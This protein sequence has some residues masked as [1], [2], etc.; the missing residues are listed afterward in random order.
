[1][2]YLIKC[3]I[4]FM[5][6]GLAV[7]QSQAQI[8]LQLSM[9]RDDYILYEEVPLVVSIHNMSTRPVTLESGEDGKSWLFLQVYQGEA[10]MVREVKPL[11]LTD[12]VVVPPGESLSRQINLTPLFELRHRGLYKVQ[13]MVKSGTVSAASRTFEF[14]LINGQE[15]W[16]QRVGVRGDTQAE[17]SYRT[18][19][20]QLR[21]G[22]D[23]DYLYACVR[24]DDSGLVYGMLP[25]GVYI[26]LEPP[27]TMV[28]RTTDLHVMLRCG[29]RQMAYAKIDVYA[30][31]L[32]R[33]IYTDL[34]TAPY[35]ARS[36]NGSVAV[37]G[38]E[39]I[40][41]R[42]E[43]VMSAEELQPPPPPPQKK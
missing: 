1:M 31:I 19:A 3:A 38:G 24:D 32:D 43:R 23:H 42:Q 39:K 29:P 35:L 2:A 27:S 15:L 4:I 17:D 41:P 21:R 28:D 34:S 25:L 40:Y 18:Y 30:R 9:E 36:A 22:K 12:S 6:T 10:D 11:V 26:P 16:K 7:S 5:A 13:A 37:Q 20:L 8:A 14:S 33:A